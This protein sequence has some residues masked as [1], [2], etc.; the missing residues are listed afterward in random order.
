MAFST[1]SAPMIAVGVPHLTDPP[2][3][4]STPATFFK[5]GHHAM[6]DPLKVDPELIKYGIHSEI[7]VA[8][9]NVNWLMEVRLV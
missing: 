9:R 1:T 2:L 7:G 8:L 5:P 6:P 3:M 4:C